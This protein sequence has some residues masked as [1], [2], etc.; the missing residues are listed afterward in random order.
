MPDYN[1]RCIYNPNLPWFFEMEKNFNDEI[2]Y[3]TKG[4]FPKPPK[5]VF[6][7]ISALVIFTSQPRIPPCN[8]IQEATFRGIPII[9][10][11]EVYQMMLQQGLLNNYLLPVDH[12]FV[13]SDC[14]RD[15]F[16]ELGVPVEILEV[17]GYVFG[18]RKYKPIN[19]LQKLKSNFDLSVL[20]STA[21][22]CFDSLSS[23]PN[24]LETSKELLDCVTWSLPNKYEL[25]I[26]PH[27][28]DRK[29]D[30]INLVKRYS[31]MPKIADPK[32]SIDEVLDVTDILL[33]RGNSQVVIDA[34]QRKIPVV[35][36]PLGRKTF[37]H[38]ILDEVIVNDNNLISILNLIEA[39]GT[40]L[41]DMIFKKYLSISLEEAIKKAIE[42]IDQIVE[43]KE[44]YKPKERLLELAIFWAWMGYVPM[45]LKILQKVDRNIQNNTFL[46]KI[47][48]L[49]SSK[50][51]KIDLV[52]FK[53]Q[54]GNSYK[55][56]ILQ[57]LWIKTLFLRNK[58]MDSQ[59]K[60]WL[61]NYPPNMNKESFL[62]YAILLYWCYLNSGMQK[63]GEFLIN[64][65]C[66]EF[67]LLKMIQKLKS[68]NLI[69][70]RKLIFNLRYLTSRI[71][72]KGTSVF[73]NILK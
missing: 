2:V 52:F 18:Y 38:G 26:K 41:Y 13:A 4:H 71:K 19:S 20:K 58:R 21:T 69:E 1:L 14:E 42:R 55:E 53:K 36:I 35:P 62:T 64:N 24:G 40:D 3:F 11:E 68:L 37:F 61:V 43:K 66:R 28:E 70:R 45:A 59:D 67:R 51:Q 63:E 30:F 10:I 6:Q 72:Y 57:S 8:L 22:L 5:D 49:V 47:Y 73:K 56:W 44:V 60:E 9:A 48:K 34:L 32:I 7:D 54:Y 46:E 15:K 29:S 27:P 16:I 39:K 12:F 25:L 17:T 23:D 33:N 50:A 31:P 65:L